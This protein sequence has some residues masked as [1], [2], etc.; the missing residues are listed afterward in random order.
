M[1][2]VTTLIIV[3]AIMATVLGGVT[4]LSHIYN[5]MFQKYRIT[6]IE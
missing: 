1:S 3:G 6:S 5:L 4:L 2:G